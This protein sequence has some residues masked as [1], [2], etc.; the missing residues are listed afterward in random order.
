MALVGRS[1]EKDWRLRLWT[2]R[3]TVPGVWD[4]QVPREAATTVAN[5]LHRL[6]LAHSVHHEDLGR[7]IEALMDRN[8]DIQVIPTS[9]LVPLSRSNGTVEYCRS[10]LLRQLC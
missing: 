7:D 9:S 5:G 6:D 10:Q 3:P 2:E 4:V 1:E 8:A